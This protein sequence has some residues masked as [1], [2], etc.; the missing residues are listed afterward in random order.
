MCNTGP[1]YAKTNN[2]A[3]TI[4][5]QKLQSAECT[6]CKKSNYAEKH[7]NFYSNK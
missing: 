6:I 1:K 4:I 7:K 3:K 2:Y 5:M